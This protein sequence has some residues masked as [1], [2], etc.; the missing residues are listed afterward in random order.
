MMAAVAMGVPL[1]GEL[2]MSLPPCEVPTEA[3][4]V[5]EKVGVRLTVAPYSG[6]LV[7]ALI[8]SLGL[9]TTPNRRL[10]TWLV[11]PVLDAVMP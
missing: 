8:V 9:T 2:E 6:V 10:N 4:A 7:E 11:P 1:V 3:E 5:L